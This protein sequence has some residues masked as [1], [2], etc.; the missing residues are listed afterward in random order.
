MSMARVKSQQNI[1][2]SFLLIFITDPYI[3]NKYSIVV[4]NGFCEGKITDKN[5]NTI[6][7][8]TAHRFLHLL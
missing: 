1:I 4:L 8:A 3:Q 7:T 6:L 5:L 2:H